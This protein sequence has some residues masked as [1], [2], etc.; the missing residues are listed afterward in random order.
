MARN[1]FT[2]NAYERDL[3]NFLAQEKEEEMLGNIHHGYE[4]KVEYCLTNS[5][6]DCIE[7][8]E[9]SVDQRNQLETDETIK[10][11]EAKKLKNED[12]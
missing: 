1:K 8:N 10:D 4:A 3:E 11:E 5:I 9:D 2:D 7:I 12:Q 6:D